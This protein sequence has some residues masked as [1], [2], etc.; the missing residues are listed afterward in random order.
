VARQ[1][2]L[3][4]KYR[5]NGKTTGIL[6]PERISLLEEVGFDWGYV[7]ADGK[8]TAKG[9]K[10]S[11]GKVE[12]KDNKGWKELMEKKHNTWLVMLGKLKEFKKENGSC[13]VPRGYALDTRL[14]NW[15]DHTYSDLVLFDVL[16]LLST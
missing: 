11:G 9:G 6:T 5:R 7:E 1:R 14:A 3:Y 13:I 16:D 2:K 8:K 15:Y 12:Q 10:K 4:A